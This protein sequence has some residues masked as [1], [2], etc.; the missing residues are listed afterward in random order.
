MKRV[1]AILITL[2]PLLSIAQV[3]V[4]MATTP[5]NTIEYRYDST[6][7]VMN[8]VQ[9]YVGQD[10]FVIP[11]ASSYKSSF[12]L[13][14]R[15]GKGIKVIDG[16]TWLDAKVAFDEVQG[17]TFHVTGVQEKK[18]RGH[19]SGY[20][21]ILE[22]TE[23]GEEILF[24]N[25]TQ[26]VN[27]FPFITLGFKEKYERDNK[28][29]R[30]VFRSYTL[31]DFETGEEIDAHKTT[32]TFKEI[33]AMPDVLEAGY[34]LVNDAGASTA[35]TDMSKFIKEADIKSF[36]KKYGSSMVDEALD[37]NIRKGM[38]SVLVKIAK[39]QPDKINSASY[40]QQW[41][42]KNQYIYIKDGKVTDWN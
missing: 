16:S 39:G 5:K 42:Y 1:L 23:T 11:A 17:R 33:I 36:T 12:S 7:N 40:G 19:L 31:Y 8:F 41:V 10:L 3:R 25:L 29:K 15:F 14:G 21:L 4:A 38:P 18:I 6:K 37:G 32:W 28:D 22:D 34:Y 13:D 27:F 24:D 2:L 9:Y 30:F 20:F 35:V 26:A